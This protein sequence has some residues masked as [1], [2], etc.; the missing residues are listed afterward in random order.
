MK[1]VVAPAV[2]IGDEWLA[3][4]KGVGIDYL[5]SFSG[6]FTIKSHLRT[7]TG[8]FVWSGET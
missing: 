1:T 4:K 8:L 3:A 6:G 7:I 2:Q 5:T